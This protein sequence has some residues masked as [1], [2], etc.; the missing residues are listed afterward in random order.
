MALFRPRSMSSHASLSGDKRTNSERVV[1]HHAGMHAMTK[2]Q[3]LLSLTLYTLTLV[4]AVAADKFKCPSPFKPNTPAKLEEIKGLLPNV[5]AM[6]DIG[7]L[8]VTIGTLRREGMPKNLIIDHLIGA[9][10]PMIDREA[11]L[12]EA[13][14]AALVGRFS[15]Q[16][17]RLVYSLE[18]GLDIIINVP[19]T[20]DIVEAV[21]SIA[22]KQ[23]LSGPAWIAMTIDNA[24]QQQ[25]AAQR[26]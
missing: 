25:N 10:C 14:K 1:H 22:R 23:G 2:S 13:E 5:H 19:L 24:L 18:S 6:A 12:T 8:N 11:S 3:I 15:G 4:P 26:Q 9:Y 21:N 17:T 20:P 16:V 7:Q